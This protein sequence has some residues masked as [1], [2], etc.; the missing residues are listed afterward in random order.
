MNPL[1]SVVIPTYQ[2]AASLPKCLDSIFAQ[3]YRPLEVIVVDDGSTDDTQAVLARYAERIVSIR[4]ENAGANPAR[5][6][7]LH[8]A[9]GD[10][11]IFCDA[12][13][14]MSP[15]MLERMYSELTRH[16]EASYAYSGFWFGWKHFKGIS[17]SADGLK[18]TNFV[19]TSSLV[20][21]SDFPGFDDAIKRLQDWDVWLTMLEHGKVG[22]LVPETLFSVGIDGASRIGS[23]WLP[24][25]VYRLPWNK[26]GWMPNRVKKYEAARKIIQTKHHL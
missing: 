6:R 17:F 5:N 3:T 21:R 25:F 1:I 4:Q 20:R 18:R 11:V 24:A 22:I 26:M 19:H 2:H 8:E 7:G 16:P 23:S 13:V 10:Y 14:T 12:D 9:K 15:G